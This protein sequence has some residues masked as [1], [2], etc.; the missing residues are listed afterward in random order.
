MES[1]WYPGR[2]INYVKMLRA[3]TG[4]TAVDRRSGVGCVLS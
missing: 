4:A 2:Q 1:I 3:V